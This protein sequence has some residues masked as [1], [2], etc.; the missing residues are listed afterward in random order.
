MEEWDSMRDLFG[1]VSS[2]ISIE[3]KEPEGPVKGV[4][5]DA[6]LSNTCCAPPSLNFNIYTK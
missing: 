2:G 6:I 4:L 5:S 3:E 1:N